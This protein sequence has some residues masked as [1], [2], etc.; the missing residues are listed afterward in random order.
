MTS[1]E[2]LSAALDQ[3]R[4]QLAQDP[5]MSAMIDEVVADLTQDQVPVEL[6]GELIIMFSET[7]KNPETYPQVMGQLIS[8]GLMDEEDIPPEFD[9]KFV[10][11]VMCALDLVRDNAAQAVP[12]QFS[13]GGLA[14]AGRNGDT[15]VAHINPIEARMLLRNGGRGSINPATGLPEFGFFKK[16]KKVFKK[17]LKPVLTVASI[18]PGPW[19]VPALALN[20]AY[21]ASQGNWLGAA[22]SAFG[23][24]A[25]PGGFGGF[26]QAGS[27]GSGITGG[28][29]TGGMFGS[30]GGATSG[31]GAGLQSGAG[32]SGS[33]SGG[34]GA[35]S[36]VGSAAASGMGAAGG[37]GAGVSGG[38]ELG[39]LGLESLSGAGSAASGGMEGLGGLGDGV[40]GSIPNLGEKLDP[41]PWEMYKT[42]KNAYGIGSKVY[43]QLNPPEPEEYSQ[44]NTQRQMQQLGGMP[45][46]NTNKAFGLGGTQSRGVGQTAN[47][48]MGMRSRFRNGGLARCT[49]KGN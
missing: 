43:N 1:I 41:T 22:L 21:S 8:A 2:D 39:G 32:L 23:A 25:A 13:R 46:I 26:G 7:L 3:Y 11:L 40:S 19:Q 16:L 38:L 47:L 29:D 36:S 31:A 48:G 9:A 34:A 45:G 12:A 28:I 20:A 6:L 14:Q 17:I 24:Y 18:I 5:T 15:M 27:T 10:A 4:E 44:Q 49:C 37:L 42:A 35:A 33:L 30:L